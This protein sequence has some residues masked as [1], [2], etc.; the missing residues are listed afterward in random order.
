MVFPPPSSSRHRDSS[1]ASAPGNR[2]SS[3]SVVSGFQTPPLPPSLGGSSAGENAPTSGRDSGGSRRESSGLS[4][5]TAESEDGGVAAAEAFRPRMPSESGHETGSSSGASSGGGGRI[6]GA[7]E[8]LQQQHVEV[9]RG[10][11]ALSPRKA[12]IAPLPVK[13]ES[14]E[15]GSGA[16]EG[17]ESRHV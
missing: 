5:N 8:A 1:S 17:R 12:R 16:N 11:V 9:E 13:A 4:F 7:S 3:G 6:S 15:G 14:E 2:D 10:A